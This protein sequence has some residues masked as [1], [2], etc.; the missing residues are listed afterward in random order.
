MDP[1]LE[2]PGAFTIPYTIGN[3]EFAKALCD[4]GA[5]I[6]LMPY[7]VFKNLGIGQPTRIS[8]RLQMANRTMKR[9]LGVIEDVL[10]DST[11]AVLQKRKKAIG[12]TLA[13]I[14]G[15]RPAFCMHKINLDE[16]SKPSIEHQRRLNEAMHEVVKKEIIKLVGHA[17][18]CFL[19]GYSGYNQ[20]LIA[21]EDQDKTTF[22]C[23]YGT[24]AFKRMPFGLCNAPMTFQ[25][26]MMAIFMDMVEYYLEVFIDDFSVV[27]YYFDDCLANLDKVL[28]RPYLM[29]AMIIVH[30]DHATLCYLMRKKDS[31][32]RLMRWVLLL[33]EFDI[34]IQDRKGSENQVADHLSR[35]EKEG[36]LHDGFEINDS[37]R[38]EQLL[39]ISMKEVPWFTYL[40]NFLMCGIIPD[41][42]SSNQR[43]KLKRDCQEYCWD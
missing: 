15:I 40:V 34:D 32:S 2:D 30:T 23:P 37:F 29:G 17:F 3:A 36:R 14:R 19:G 8:I 13:D 24:F 26:C 20:I 4:L 18:Y 33:Q 7:L 27:G 38:D 42:F 16:V 25:R 41:E 6:N 5:S 21:P 39:A 1:K 31:K 28:F 22:I 10:V 12:W 9:P 11:L 35:L 43:K